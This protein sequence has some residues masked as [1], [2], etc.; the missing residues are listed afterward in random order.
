MEIM[1]YL[2]TIKMKNA[3]KLFDYRVYNQY[4]KNST[5]FFNSKI[6]WDFGNVK[7]ESNTHWHDQH[8]E[9]AKNKDNGGWHN[10]KSSDFGVDFNLS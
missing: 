6:L 5:K 4:E 1:M 3:F 9:L 8:N 2:C 7:L 10:Y